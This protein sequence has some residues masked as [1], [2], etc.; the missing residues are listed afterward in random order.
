MK[1]ALS[2]FLLTAAASFAADDV[3]MRA[4]RDELARSMKKL[5]LESLQKPYFIAYRMVENTGCNAIATFGALN[6]SNCDAAVES[7][8]RNLSV[9]VHVG[10]YARDNTNFFVPMSVGGVARPLGSGG[11][12]I[13]VE[14]NYDEIRRQLWLATDS[15]YKN[16]LDLYA[17]KKATLENRH[18]TEDA[19]DFSKE[20]PLNMDESMPRGAWNRTAFE[21]IVKPLSAIFRETPAAA[22]SEVRLMAQHWLVRYVNSE[23]TSYTRDNS[24]L[25]LQV[26]AAGQAVDG[27]T[28]TDF[29]VAY[30]HTIDQLPPM[31]EMTKRVH[32][33]AA[34]LASLQKA[35]LVEKY[36]GP[37]LFEGQGVA[38][39]F[40]QGIG[41]VLVGVPRVVVDDSRLE[42]IYNNNAGFADRIGARILP[43]FVTITDDPSV[44]DFHRQPLFGG[45]QFDDEGVKASPHVIVQNGILKLL[46][47][48]RA[49]L[50]GTT[51]STA[52]KR[53]MYPS[54][55]NLIV[56]ASR[57]MTANQLKA[58]LLRRVADRG[59]PF[60][61]V[62]RRIGNPQLSQQLNRSVIII[63]SNS[64]GPGSLPIESINEAYKTFP[65]GH[66]ELAR[67]LTINGMTLANFKD[68]VAVSDTPYVYT[69]PM[70]MMVRTPVMAT[71]FVAPGSPNV[72]S[73]AVP[74][75]LFDELV[76]QRP[77]GEIPTLPFTP[78]PTL[79]P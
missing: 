48:S 18:R 68:I 36:T 43:D 2:A 61:I 26:N 45:Y 58:D 1:R 5:Q 44:H 10:D 19:P 16:S 51:Q 72:V 64:G 28:L 14:D 7:R 54:P 17:K 35:A 70:R 15:A 59:L 76:L 50:P 32:A 38:E 52:S 4:M 78:R 29:D 21:N 60:G 11:S 13:P 69:S 40:C 24:F 33:L 8:F 46:L 9:E 67:N 77:A 31:T 37:V 25:T 71:S 30:A 47:H 20:P 41:N 73:A 75:L 56:S 39:I 3:V 57:T 79:K 49:L 27:M 42:N 74:S 53:G 62:V 12:A 55:T 63:G 23:G 22:D 65:D 6:S 66:E 34:R